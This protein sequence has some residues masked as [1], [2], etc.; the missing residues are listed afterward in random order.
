[1]NLWQETLDALKHYGKTFDDVIVVYGREFTIPKENFIE[2][3]KKTEYYEGHG[4]QN[5]AEDLRILGHG[6]IMIRG[7]YDGAEWWEYIDVTTVPKKEKTITRL[8]GDDF[9]YNYLADIN[10]KNEGEE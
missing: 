8:A 6:F 3:A 7:E 1:M 4:H 10:D 2:V 5:V 9:S